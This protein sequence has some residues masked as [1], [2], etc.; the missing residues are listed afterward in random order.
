MAMLQ[1]KDG[2]SRE[3]ANQQFGEKA[4]QAALDEITKV[5]MTPQ[6]D[7][8]YRQMMASGHPYGALVRWH[9][10]A[11]AQQ[12]I[13]NDPNAWLR[14]RQQEWVRDPNAQKAVLEYLRQQQTQQGRGQPPSVQLPPSLSTL[15]GSPAGAE[16]IGDLSDASLYAFATAPPRR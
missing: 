4:V 5:R 11:R 10:Q 1:I 16:P 12:A 9:A 13:G 3:M 15:P 2:L 6:G 8:A 14:A 7:F